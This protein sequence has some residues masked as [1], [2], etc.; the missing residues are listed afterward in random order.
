MK[1]F[2]YILVLHEGTNTLICEKSRLS[3]KPE[4]VSR[5]ISNMDVQQQKKQ[6]K[7]VVLLDLA[8]DTNVTVATRPPRE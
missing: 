8:Q 2:A 4:F 5:S 6:M 7:L 3:L 1:I